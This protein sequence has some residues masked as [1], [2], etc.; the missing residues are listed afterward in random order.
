MLRKGDE[1]HAFVCP[2]GG[3][4]REIRHDDV[5][6]AAATSVHA[7]IKKRGGSALTSQAV[8]EKGKTKT[9]DILVRLGGESAVGGH[10]G[11]LQRQK[12]S[13]RAR[14]RPEEW[15]GRKRGGRV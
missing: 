2:K 8:G 3:G 11:D 12:E 15:G 5:N 4:I 6:E 10:N 14:E 13:D 7:A 1:R 9:T